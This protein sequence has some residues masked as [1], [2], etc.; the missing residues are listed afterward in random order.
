MPRNLS[1]EATRPE[2][3]RGPAVRKA[4]VCSCRTEGPIY[5]CG[6]HGG[7]C[8]RQTLRR[9]LS[10][11]TEGEILNQSQLSHPRLDGRHI[12]VNTPPTGS[13]VLHRFSLFCC[14]KFKKKQFLWS[15]RI[16]VL[17]EMKIARLQAQCRWFFDRAFAVHLHA[18]R[19]QD[20]SLMNICLG[21][22]QASQSRTFLLALFSSD[23]TDCFRKNN[24]GRKEEGQRRNVKCLKSKE[25]NRMIS[26][27]Q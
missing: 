26:S 19:A 17:L 16:P 1:E 5:V 18:K 11:P 13:P 3:G 9:V 21:F 12:T 25:M 24:G 20:E 22:I 27:A 8:V 14:C 6:V 7:S 15:P 23:A 2:Y 4:S 10:T